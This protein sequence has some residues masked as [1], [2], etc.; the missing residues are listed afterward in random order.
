MNVS[1]VSYGAVSQ[2]SGQSQQGFRYYF[3]QLSQALQ[4]GDLSAAQ[5]AYASLSQL[6]QVQNSQNTILTQGLSAIGTALQSGNVNGAEQAFTSM[7]Q[8]W[9]SSV[10][11][12]SGATGN[13]Q[14]A[15]GHHH[16]HHHSGGAS[17]ASALSASS[18]TSSAGGDDGS[19]ASSGGDPLLSILTAVENTLTNI[20]GDLSGNSD[21]ITTSGG[22]TTNTTDGG[23][24]ISSVT[25]ATSANPFG[26]DQLLT[27][28][29]EIENTLT[30]IQG[31]LPSGLSTSAVNP[32]NAV[33]GTTTP[34]VN[35]SV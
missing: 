24:A 8:Q 1:N 16:H 5:Q 28:L 13:T 33:S 14:Q 35:I 10:Q 18:G 32:T 17:D 3:N 9:R 15:G 19:G 25:G 6:P 4:S 23:T 2:S 34:P 29:G 20:Q 11:A 21:T 7:Q 30:Q 27:L 26:N 22:A 12:S 31:D